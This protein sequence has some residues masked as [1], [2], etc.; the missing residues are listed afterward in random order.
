M[1]QNSFDMRQKIS[2][3]IAFTFIILLGLVLSWYSI[4]TSEDILINMP[5]SKTMDINK[6]MQE[7]NSQ[8]NAEIQSVL[9][10][11]GVQVNINSGK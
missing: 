2:G 10:E 1:I 7:K 6:R 4:K 5:K 11:G 9:K 8:R 3:F